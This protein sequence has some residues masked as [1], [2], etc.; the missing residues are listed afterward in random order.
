MYLDMPYLGQ[1]G[2]YSISVLRQHRPSTFKRTSKISTSMKLLSW[3]ESYQ[4]Q[5]HIV[6]ISSQIGLNKNAIAF[7]DYGKQWME[8]EDALNSPIPISSVSPLS[9][10]RFT[11]FAQASLSWFEDHL[12]THNSCTAQVYKSL[13]VSTLLL[14]PKQNVCSM[15]NSLCS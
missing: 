11:A 15:K 5:L 9:Q 1:D 12:E 8:C 6:Q 2:S 14:N 10:F 4:H 3:L 7:E 13:P